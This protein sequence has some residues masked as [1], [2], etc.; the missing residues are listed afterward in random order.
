MSQDVM[1]FAKCYIKTD[2][3]HNNAKPLQTRTSNNSK[4]CWS[5]ETQYKTNNNTKIIVWF[6]YQRYKLLK[7]NNIVLPILTFI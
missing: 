6:K 3:H 7:I 5:V 2:R 4:I 1:H